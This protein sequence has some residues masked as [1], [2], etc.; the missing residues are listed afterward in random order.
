MET[1]DPPQTPQEKNLSSNNN[2]TSS[3]KRHYQ[4]TEANEEEYEQSDEIQM[5]LEREI[6]ELKKLVKK[7]T[8]KIRTLEKLTHKLSGDTSR[9]SEDVD[10]LFELVNSISDDVYTD[11]Q[12]Y[13]ADS[14]HVEAP[15]PESEQSDEDYHPGDDEDTYTGLSYQKAALAKFTE[16]LNVAMAKY[17]SNN[18]PTL[19]NS[20][21]PATKKT[22]FSARI[23]TKNTKNNGKKPNYNYDN[24]GQTSGSEDENKE[25]NDHTGSAVD[26]SCEEHCT[27]S[28]IS[29]GDYQS[30]SPG[31]PIAIPIN[32]EQLAKIYNGTAD[33]EFVK[34]II[35]KALLK[36]DPLEFVA[37]YCKEQGFTQKKTTQLKNQTKEYLAL[38]AESTKETSDLEHFLYTPEPTRKEIIKSLEYIKTN[39]T[40]DK[41]YKFRIL[42]SHLENYAKNIALYKANQLEDSE[43]GTGE[44]YKL[45]NWI[46][47]LLDIPW[48]Q[49]KYIN[50]NS[51]MVGTY[52]KNARECMNR[53]I[54][55]QDE[56]K[57]VIIQIISKMITNPQKSGNVFAVYGPPG[58]GKTTI[59]KEGMSQALGLPFAFIS[60]GGATDSSYLDGHGY[61]Y[62]GST[63]GKIVELLKKSKCMNPIFYFDELDKVSD[64]R[65]GEEIANLLIHLTDP[66][67]NNMFQDKYLGNVNID[68]SKS[69][70]VFSFN[71]ITRVNPILLDRMELIYVKGFT[72]LE[73]MRITRDYL[74]PELLK[75]YCLYSQYPLQQPST[76]IVA[77]TTQHTT[78]TDQ[79]PDVIFNDECLEYIITY[80]NQQAKEDGVRQI[81]RRL[82]KICA[83]LNIL[84]I[85]GDECHNIHSILDSIPELKQ[86]IT[87]PL[88]LSKDMID[89]L[90]KIKSREDLAPPFG[91][92]C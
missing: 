75:L 88:V 51:A 91:M 72:L 64:T 44:Y 24:L 89:K 7:Q 22:R 48:G 32:K 20:E 17:Q 5:N 9:V 14:Y 66:S 63:P 62:E 12:E 69:I 29:P 31:Q 65:K 79:Q 4:Q 90:L 15:T 71:D 8:K 54:Y 21:Q 74:L 18:Q 76:P 86:G 45:K 77:G 42:A 39:N 3:R 6:A 84:K 41:P 27:E 35:N 58:V 52:L 80:N 60:L 59:I 43:P 37:K 83:Q 23:A 68:L 61:T 25:D 26:C 50:V 67:Q 57:D 38:T 10:E 53:V 87:W 82:E 34:S 13:P 56:T 28:A 70:F 73:K 81:K 49:H 47:T 1:S 2:Q 55:G 40:S 36:A 19:A 78:A 92:Y 85:T 33:A 30:G 46:D 16:Q 11:P